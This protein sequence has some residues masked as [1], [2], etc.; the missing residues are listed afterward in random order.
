MKDIL[1]ACEYSG[2]MR[3]A[4]RERGHNAWSC[5]L[6]PADDGDKHHFQCDVREVLTRGWDMMI[7]HPTCTR[8]CNSG[9]RWLYQG[10][11][12]KVPDPKMWR[13]ML[14]GVEFYNLLW[15]ADIP[16]IAV[17]NPIM[18]DHAR[19]L[20]GIRPGEVQFVQPWW[21]GDKAFKATG[22]RLKNLPPLKPTNKLT[23]PKPGTEEHKQWS[24]IHRAARTAD[25]WKLRSTTFPGIADACG[26]QWGVL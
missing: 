1:I 22:F 17:E 24:F 19:K 4:F 20:L 12:G 7:A 2:A 16:R 15:N 25:R 18:H 14:D 11:R 8:L 13:D 5:D 23:P 6:L 9:R 21:F 26:E 3:R 10:G